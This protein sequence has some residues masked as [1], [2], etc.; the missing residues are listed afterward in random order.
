[1]SSCLPFICSYAI[2]FVCHVQHAALLY[3]FL[4]R[5]KLA[6]FVRTVF[7]MLCVSKQKTCLMKYS[8]E[9]MWQSVDVMLISLQHYAKFVWRVLV[10]LIFLYHARFHWS[11]CNMVL[12]FLDDSQ[13]ACVERYCLMCNW[14]ITFFGWAMYT[15]CTSRNAC[16]QK[17]NW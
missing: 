3:F 16:W 8:L 12:V 10:L 2:F 14:S 17:T 9:C 4:K 11:L 13:F 5:S 6:W 1:M 15:L 7:L